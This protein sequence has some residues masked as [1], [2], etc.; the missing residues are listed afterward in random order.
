MERLPVR[1][2]RVSAVRRLTPHMARITFDGDDL[3]DFH[4]DEPDQQ[5]KLYFPKPGQDVPRMPEPGGDFL[6]WYQAFNDIPE[7]ERPWMRSYTIRAHHQDSGTIDVDFVLHADA[8]PATRWAHTARPGDVIAMFGPSA[9]FARATPIDTSIRAA[10]WVL[11]AGDDTAVPAIGALLESLPAGTRAIAYL[12]VGGAVERQR[13]DTRGEVTVHWLHRDGLKPGHSELL[14]DAVRAAEFPPGPV[15]A[16][17]A[18]EAGVVRALRRHLTTERGVPKQAIEFTGHWRLTL[19]QDDAPTEEDLAEAR[20]RVADAKAVF[21]EAYRSRTAPWVIGGPQPA[22]VELERDGWIRGTVLDAG[23]GTG[24][25]TIHLARLGYDVRGI[26]YAPG[27]I[28]D[29]RARAAEYG[30]EARFEV[31]DALNL[32]GE[33]GYDTVLDSALFHVFDDGERARYVRGLHAACRPGAR[34]HV[35]ALSDEGPGF[36]PQISESVIREAF[37]DGWVLEELRTSRYRGAIGEQGEPGD[38]PAWLA[39]VRRV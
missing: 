12:E 20:E 14:P 25:H 2:I 18:G 22:I 32:G 36:G 10:G 5:V 17:L 24:E 26:D 35:L 3:T 19:T 23:C 16:W 38:L 11:L 21:D 6:A 27:A 37:G 15:F 33:P 1:F 13:F 34:V 4:Y 30:V 7:H 29:A 8:G 28:D 9:A 31:A 39:R